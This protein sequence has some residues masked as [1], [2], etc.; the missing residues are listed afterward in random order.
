MDEKQPC[1]KCNEEAP[2]EP[3]CLDC[4]S[5][6]ELTASQDKRLEALCWALLEWS[7]GTDSWKDGSDDE[8]QFSSLLDEIR[9][10]L[11]PENYDAAILEIAEDED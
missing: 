9:G 6:L 8:V 5:N 10:Q 3:V 11:S 1:I 7:E 4:L 2:V